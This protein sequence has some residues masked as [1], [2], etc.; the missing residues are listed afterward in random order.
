[1]RRKKAV[2]LTYLSLGRIWI[3]ENKMEAETFEGS[4]FCVPLDPSNFQFPFPFLYPNP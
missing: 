3:K 1:M 4:I 2:M